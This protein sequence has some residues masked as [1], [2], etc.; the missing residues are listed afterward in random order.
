VNEEDS[1]RDRAE[2]EGETRLVRHFCSSAECLLTPGSPRA[3]SRPQGLATPLGPCGSY[4]EGSVINDIKLPPTLFR[5]CLA[6]TSAWWSDWSTKAAACGIPGPEH[7]FSPPAP[8]IPRTQYFVR[9]CSNTQQRRSLSFK[10]VQ[11]N[12]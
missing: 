12:W 3:Q 5:P 4:F 2:E 10:H 8:H 7:A 1:E 6:Y 11:K 9:S